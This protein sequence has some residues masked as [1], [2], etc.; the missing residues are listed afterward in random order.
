MSILVAVSK[1]TE[2][3]VDLVPYSAQECASK[4]WL[5]RRTPGDREVEKTIA[6]LDDRT[7]ASTAQ[8]FDRTEL[9]GPPRN[10][11]KFRHLAGDL[12]EF[13][14]HR[15][16]AM[17]YLAFQVSVGWMVAIARR[18]PKSKELGALIAATQRMHD[19][20]EGEQQ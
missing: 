9:L 10:V 13:K 7:L 19:E 5:L 3:V 12:Y 6:R 20:F 8:L 17:R 16:V 1:E 2:I 15:A 4:V 18:K 11:E 14:V